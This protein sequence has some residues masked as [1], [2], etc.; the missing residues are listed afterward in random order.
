MT[1]TPTKKTT[2]YLVASDFDQTLSFN[3]SGR[4]LADIVGIRDFEEKVHGLASRAPR[5]AGR[6]A[7]LPVAPRS[8]V[9]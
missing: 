6:R 9:P 3:D 2:R 7:R 5:A 8:R 1:T 4:V